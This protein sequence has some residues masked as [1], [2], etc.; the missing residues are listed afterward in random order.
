MK[1]TFLYAVLL[2]AL[3]AAV[4]FLCLLPVFPA[5]LAPVSE[6]T[7]DEPAA[8]TAAP[9]TDATAVPSA[10]PLPEQA[11]IYLYDEAAGDVIAV[12]VQEFLIGAAACEMPA[13]WPDDALRAQ[14]VASHSYALYQK[15]HGGSISAGYLTVNSA[16]CSGWASAEVLQ[17]RWGDSY[18]EYHD[19][20]AALAAEVQ[21]DVL[22]YGGEP[23]AACY[24]A[25]SCGATE[26]SQNVWLESLPY[27]QGVDSTWDRYAD[28]F[29]VTI[30]YTTQQFS[31]AMRM[32]LGI[33]P[34]GEPSTWLGDTEWDT[35]G[36][37]RIIELCGESVSGTAVRGAFS[38]RSACFAMA[39]RDGQ[40]VITTRGYGHGVGL[41]QYGAR[42]MAQGGT[43]WRDIL[44]YYF[45]GTVIGAG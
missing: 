5:G 45:P 15:D 39:L 9:R 43:G 7:V 26:A 10:S 11:P 24:H 31:D 33:T 13:T 35:A 42:A 44:T 27:L 20:L 12:P 22:L 3:A 1:R 18:S 17:S 4:P 41:S 34:E 25:I 21:Y 40:F 30:Q 16:Q 37:V 28:D 36:Y 2:A 32:N 8:A 6:K 19:R 38:L 14:M 23:A 29:E